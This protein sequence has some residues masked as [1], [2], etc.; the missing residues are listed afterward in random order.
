MD[1]QKQTRAPQTLEEMWEVVKD[2]IITTIHFQGKS[3]TKRQLQDKCF[4]S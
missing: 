3:Y 1:T 4:K 2:K